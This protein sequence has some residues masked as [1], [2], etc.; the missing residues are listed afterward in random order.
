MATLQGDDARTSTVTR[1]YDKLVRDRI[2]QLVEDDGERPVVHVADDREYERRLVEKLFEEA[3]EYRESGEVAELADLLEVV[4]AIRAHEGVSE[5]EL[6]RL[7]A[8]K[9]SERGR[10][11]ERIVLERV[12]PE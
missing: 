1:E 9:A 6:K 3:E 7:R 11:D 4:H 10:F 12:E 2:P 5:A 8:E